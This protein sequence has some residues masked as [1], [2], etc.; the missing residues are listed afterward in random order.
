MS[1][2]VQRL[3]GHSSIE[4]TMKY[5]VGIRDEMID[6]ARHASQLALGDDSVT[7]LSQRPK[8]S[9][10]SGSIDVIA[11]LQ[12]LISAGVIRIGATGLEPATS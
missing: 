8:N 9:K 5:Y 1:H 10:K 4:T 6:K 7:V 3:A 11:A 2:E 12:T